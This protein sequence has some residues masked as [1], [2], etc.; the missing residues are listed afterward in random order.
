MK[1]V[2]LLLFGLI[3]AC[4]VPVIRPDE[5]GLG[6]AGESVQSDGGC[7]RGLIVAATD[8]SQSANIGLM[9]LSGQVL[10]QSI[11]STASHAPELT[12][13]L[14]GDIA[15]PST[16]TS[17]SEIIVLDRTPT[18]VLTWVNLDTANVRAQLSVATG[19]SANP[20][21]Y[22]PILTNKVYV[23]RFDSNANPG[24][25]AFDGGSDVL[26]VD[27]SI[28]SITGRIDLAG[29]LPQSGNYFVH[30]DRARSVG[31]RVYIVLPYYDPAFNAGQSYI[32]SID[33]E[34]DEVVDQ[35]L[36]SGLS[37]CSGLD[38]APDE[39]S[40]AVACS[41]GWH[42]SSSADPSTSAIIGLQLQPKLVE[43]WRIPATK[44]GNRAF[45]FEVAYVNPN[46]IL[47]SQ[48]GD[49]GP[50]LINDVAYVVDITTN[51]FVPILQSADVPVTLSVGP[52]KPNC[53][54]CYIADAQ[55][56][57]IHRLSFNDLQHYS[58]S[59]YSWND[60]T[61]LPPRMLGFF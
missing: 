29:A 13:A 16:S 17:G 5:S 61:G 27:P 57:I 3:Q 12:T 41:G 39:N 1:A 10:S 51:E 37:G 23:S 34:V 38:V 6:D 26:I 45:G 59:D 32:A 9:T 40:L 4:D 31:N 55:R 18:S 35:I 15:F 49:L 28:P 52:C 8:L 30:P 54:L 21:D 19:F 25:Q 43:L 2:L 24:Q 7:P 50:P 42:G 36:L 48:L 22:V 20:H 46:H 11:I 14:G 33:P 47:T 56:K 44:V 53:G 60:P 58:I